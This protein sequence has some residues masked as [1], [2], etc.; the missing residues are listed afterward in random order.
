[1]D[2]IFTALANDPVIVYLPIIIIIHI[3][4]GIAAAIKTKTFQVKELPNF[5]Y[6]G[7]L[8]FI[9]M[10]LLNYTKVVA[11]VNEM[12]DIVTTDITVLLGAAWLAVMIYYLYGIYKN[13]CALGMPKFIKFEKKVKEVAEEAA[14]E[15]VDQA[16][17][18]LNSEE[19]ADEE[20]E[21]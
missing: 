14:A 1:M 20:T 3:I 17:D 9:F 5:I 13:L 19:G 4:L 7:A 18:T 21:E 6:K 8:I 16:T 11:T 12:G 10:A 15:V 2:A